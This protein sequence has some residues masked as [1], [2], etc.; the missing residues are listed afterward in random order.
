MH[1]RCKDELMKL[2]AYLKKKDQKEF[3]KL[4]GIERHTL[5]RYLAG[6]VPAPEIMPAIY[7]VTNGK[8]QPND[9]YTLEKRS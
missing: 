2:S 4:V 1:R 8:V 7:R 9:F 3:C 6:R 5:E